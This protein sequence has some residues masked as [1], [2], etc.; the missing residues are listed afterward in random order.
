V[1]VDAKVDKK[2][3]RVCFFYCFPFG[4]GGV[5]MGEYVGRFGLGGSCMNTS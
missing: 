2:N 5:F 1:I 4:V 3:C